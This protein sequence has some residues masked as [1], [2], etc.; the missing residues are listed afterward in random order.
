VSAAVAVINLNQKILDNNGASVLLNKF[1]KQYML[2]LK[3]ISRLLI[4]TVVDQET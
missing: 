1:I 2:I 3:S 4:L